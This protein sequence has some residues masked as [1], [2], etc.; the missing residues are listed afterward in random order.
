VVSTRE[1]PFA[2]VLVSIEGDRVEVVRASVGSGDFESLT[3]D[4][5]A[6]D[7]LEG[8]GVGGVELEFVDPVRLEEVSES[9]RR[10]R[11]LRRTWG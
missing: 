8:V 1:G 4:G 7:L 2:V 3:D 9:R 10:R 5:F 11:G 6:E